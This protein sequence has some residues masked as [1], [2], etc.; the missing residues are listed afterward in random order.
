ML[1]PGTR[2]HRAIHLDSA[3]LC[4]RII[5]NHPSTLT[6]PSPEP[7]NN[8]PLHL[9]ASLGHISIVNLLISKLPSP[10]EI[11]KNSLAQT[12][13]HLAA[14]HGHAAVI[15]ALVQASPGS[16]KLRDAQGRDSLIA[17]IVG[18]H[19][20]VLPLLLAAG[21]DPNGCD[22]EGSSA[23]H[24]ASAYGELKALRILLDAGADPNQRNAW[25]WAPL[26]W[27]LSVSA[28]VY[29]RALVAEK[30]GGNRGAVRLVEEGNQVVGSAGA[31]AGASTSTGGSEGIRK[32]WVERPA[33]PGG[34]A[35]RPGTPGEG[36]RVW[37]IPRPSTPRGRAGSGD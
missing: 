20:E 35:E 4:A 18:G 34:T 27:S 36:R 5:H 21:A 25:S 11:P 3:S 1:P 19:A 31:G 7:P 13:L 28:E 15:E 24:F 29:F 2:L 6:D 8:T 33:S 22:E 10:R 16:I 30:S 12:P 32:P 26:S 9:S 37:G 17:A 14:A 23:L